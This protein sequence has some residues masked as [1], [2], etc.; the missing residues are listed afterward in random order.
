MHRRIRSNARGMQW[1]IRLHNTA[2]SMKAKR[3]SHLA[4]IQPGIKLCRFC[5]EE[6]ASGDL[7]C[8]LLII[9]AIGRYALIAT[10]NHR[11]FHG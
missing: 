1:Q 3:E 7:K 8:R 4:P 9:S 2:L 6:E 10:N 11:L 5:A